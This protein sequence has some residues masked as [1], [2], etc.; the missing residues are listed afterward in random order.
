M[1]AVAGLLEDAVLAARHHLD[2]PVAFEEP[3]H[4]ID[5]IGEHVEHRRRVRIALEDREGLR[6]RI[7]DARGAADD[8]A[9]PAVPHLLL[10]AQ[11]ALLVAAAVAD[12]QIALGRAQRVEDLVGVGERKADRLLHQHRLAELQRP[13]DRQRVLLLRRRDDHRGDV[14]MVDDLVVAAAVEVGAGLLGQRARAGGVAIGD[15]QKAHRRMLG[16]KPRAQRADAA[17]AD[18][19]DADVGLF[20]LGIVCNLFYATC[21]TGTS[22]R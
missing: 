1:R 5:V 17:G 16:G 18:D 3:A 22:R 8:L 15:R 21:R 20:H 4:Q 10:G 13:Q 19:G 14:G 2:R 12:A 11:E 7:V 6:A 9:E